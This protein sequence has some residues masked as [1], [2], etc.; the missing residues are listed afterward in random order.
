MSYKCKSKICLSSVSF[1]SLQNSGIESLVEELC[2]KLKD[3]QNKQKGLLD[4][5]HHHIWY[6]FIETINMLLNIVLTHH[7][8]ADFVLQRKNR[9]KR[10]LMALSLQSELSPPLQR[11]RWKCKPHHRHCASISFSGCRTH[12]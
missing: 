3:I 9:F 10:N 11:T 2:S 6:F 7:L 8:I 12:L 4:S 5:L 1:S